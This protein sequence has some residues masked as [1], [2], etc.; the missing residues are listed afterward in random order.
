MIRNRQ[1]IKQRNPWLSLNSLP[2]IK[3]NAFY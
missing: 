2:L 3:S 1:S